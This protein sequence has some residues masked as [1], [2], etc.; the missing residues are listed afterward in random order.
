MSVH[1]A[2]IL[3]IKMYLMN[4]VRKTFWAQS[5]QIQLTEERKN[6]CASLEQKS[7]KYYWWLAIK[8]DS[9]QSS[10]VT[11]TCAH[12]GTFPLLAPSFPLFWSRHLCDPVLIWEREHRALANLLL[13]L[14][15][16]KK[17]E[18][19]KVTVSNEEPSSGYHSWYSSSV[20]V[21]YQECTMENIFNCFWC[22]FHPKWL[23]QK[24][25]AII[26]PQMNDK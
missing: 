16:N 24:I 11:W 23:L 17:P 18:S 13:L 2:V 5:K 20:I 10:Y 26:I 7:S 8:S 14:S 6:C 4:I 1:K 15:W 25:L 12:F 9:A 21:L 19:L 3:C 22:S